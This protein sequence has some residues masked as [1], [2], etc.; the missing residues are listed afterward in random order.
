MQN[1]DKIELRL[2]SLRNFRDVPKDLLTYLSMQ[3]DSMN[4][5][6]R[7]PKIVRIDLRKNKLVQLRDEFFDAI[8]EAAR[9]EMVSLLAEQNQLFSVSDKLE[10]LTGLRVLDLSKNQLLSAPRFPGNL[11][12]LHLGDN[13][14]HT[15]FRLNLPHLELLDVSHNH[16]QALP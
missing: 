9:N 3:D 10:L 7:K 4:M 1:W 13:N 5:R 15:L 2:N 6:E 12:E 11:K 8:D 16:L 14:L